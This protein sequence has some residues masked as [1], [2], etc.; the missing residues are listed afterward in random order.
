MADASP[1]KEKPPALED[2]PFNEFIESHFVPELA[3]ALSEQ[4]LSDLD[5]QFVKRSLPTQSSAEEVW[6]ILG[7]WL[8]GQRSFVLGFPEESIKGLKVFACADGQSTPTDLEAFLIDER[9][10]NL[11]LL[12]FGVLRRL[13]GQKWLGLN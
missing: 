3:K 8:G 10:V 9:K 11:N 13:N 4:G 5:L 2:K 7:K 6:Q 12:V 1:K